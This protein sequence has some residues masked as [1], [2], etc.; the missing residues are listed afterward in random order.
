MYI[1][2]HDFTNTA[3]K[4]T[5]Q[6]IVSTIAQALQKAGH[7]IAEEQDASDLVF[8][9][10]FNAVPRT[11]KQRD[12][13]DLCVVSEFW[14]NR[15]GTLLASYIIG[16]GNWFMTGEQVAD[17]VQDILRRHVEI[18]M[19]IFPKDE[20][21]AVSFTKSLF[22]NDWFVRSGGQPQG[23][24]FVTLSSPP[25]WATVCIQDS[26]YSVIDKAGWRVCRSQDQADVIL[27]M[28]IQE[29]VGSATFMS[30]TRTPTLST[31]TYT[32]TFTASK[33]KEVS[34]DPVTWSITG[35]TPDIVS[36]PPGP[37]VEAQNILVEGIQR[38][39]NLLIST[40]ERFAP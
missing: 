38:K 12:W 11:P 13:F 31:Y 25:T 37:R 30:P 34:E 33:A 16:D 7:Q 23:L 24:V 8:E 9:L 39:A 17:E 36:S 2:V 10:R 29:T 1:V 40:L 20:V 15:G 4:A 3:T 35:S 32:A 27:E 5:R 19:I 22:G 26:L 21:S 14:E 18:G 28:S 6:E